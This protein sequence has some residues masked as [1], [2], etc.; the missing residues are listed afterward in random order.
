[1]ILD[2]VER[3]LRGQYSMWVEARWQCLQVHQ[4]AD[5]QARASQ[6]QNGESYLGCNQQ[7]SCAAVSMTCNGSLAQYGCGIHAEDGEARQ[8]P[9]EEASAQRYRKREQEHAL[10][11]PDP[12]ERD[13]LC[14]QKRN[15][16][17]QQTDSRQQPN[18]AACCLEDGALCS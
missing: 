3:G 1:M 13:K 2:L 14:R 10:I 7:L 12:A 16:R 15:Q 11:E 6:Q 5:Q 8:G 17:A 9:E 18:E 4:R